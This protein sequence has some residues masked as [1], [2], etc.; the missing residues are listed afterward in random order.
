MKEFI[1]VMKALSDSNRVRIVKM[2]QK[3]VMCVCEI[4]AALGVAQSTASKHLKILEDAGLITSFKEG[5]WVNYVLADGGASPYAASLI[6]NLKHWLEDDPA[7]TELEIRL[8]RIRREE[9][10]CR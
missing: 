4:T 10:C 9:I 8:P 1:R 2:L 5:L 3:R 7:M 6:G